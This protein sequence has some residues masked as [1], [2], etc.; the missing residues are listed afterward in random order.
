VDDAVFAQ[1]GAGWRVPQSLPLRPELQASLRVTAPLHGEVTSGAPVEMLVG[2]SVPIW[3]SLSATVAAGGAPISGAGAAD[4][5]AFVGVRWSERQAPPAPVVPVVETRTVE[6]IVE[7]TVEKIVERRIEVP[8]PAECPAVPTAEP[9]IEAGRIEIQG[10]VTFRRATAE[11]DER[12]LQVVDEVAGLLVAHP[13]V[14]QVRIEGHT[15]ADGAA[16]TNK[17]LSQR[18]AEA[19]VARLVAKG[20][21]ASRLAA[22]GYG[23]ERPVTGNDTDAGREQNRR[24]EMRVVE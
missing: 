24:V 21:E 12:G 6:K 2:A 13:E 22:E 1:L 8:V 18:R 10:K 16:Q 3:G 15:D 20:V 9:R 19:V 5:R 17:S 14:K 23:E 4:V 7:K 11:L